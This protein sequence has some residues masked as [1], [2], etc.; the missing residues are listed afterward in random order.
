MSYISFFELLFTPQ[1]P[2]SKRFVMK[3]VTHADMG[4]GSL[5]LVGLSNNQTSSL[6]QC[7]VVVLLLVLLV[8]LYRCIVDRLA[9]TGWDFGSME[10]M[11][12]Q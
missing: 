10:L 6:L 7:V 1:G 4:R 5:S 2:R 11:V 9:S 12:S 3:W 8:V